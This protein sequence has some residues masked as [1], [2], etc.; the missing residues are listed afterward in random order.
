MKNFT[1]EK[2]KVGIIGA[3]VMGSILARQLI[4]TGTVQASQIFICDRNARK[5]KKLRGNYKI[6][7]SLD[8]EEVTS[9]PLT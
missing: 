1:N 3:G 9:T 6:N 4:V 5:L 8:K 2:L 7:I